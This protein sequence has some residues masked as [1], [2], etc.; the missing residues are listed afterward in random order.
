MNLT[1]ERHS[2]RRIPAAPRK[3]PA[4]AAARMFEMIGLS[5]DHPEAV[6]VDL[7]SIAA[8][9][10]LKV[11][12]AAF[13]DPNISGM[14]ILDAGRVPPGTE[15]G[16]GG[17]I[18]LKRGEFPLRSRFTLAHEI[19]HVVLG[20]Q[21][22]GVITDFYRGR[23]DGRVDPQERDAN[24]FAAELL[25]PRKLFKQIWGTSSEEELSIVFGVSVTA[26]AVRA[27]ALGLSSRYEY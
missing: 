23:T 19:G 14:L 26:A 1:S 22:G 2:T 9:L 7:D 21:N 4:E 8:G 5:P 27:K 12:M 6:P 17:T 16:E 15:A 25:M 18:F 11:Y 3:G 13:E 24:E 20:H 10:G